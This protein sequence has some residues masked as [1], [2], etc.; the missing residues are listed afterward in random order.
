MGFGELNMRP[1][2]K[3]SRDVRGR[4]ESGA[5]DVSGRRL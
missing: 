4:K 3:Y 5:R 2:E 1:A